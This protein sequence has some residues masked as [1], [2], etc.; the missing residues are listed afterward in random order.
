MLVFGRVLILLVKPSYSG[1]K[2]TDTSRIH[3]QSEH[4]EFHDNQPS[5]WLKSPKG[6]VVGWE[7]GLHPSEPMAGKDLCI[8][9]L[10]SR[11]FYHNIPPKA[12]WQK[13]WIQKCLFG[14]KILLVFWEGQIPAPHWDASGSV[15]RLCSWFLVVS[16]IVFL[17]KQKLQ[18][19]PTFSKSFWWQKNTSRNCDPKMAIT[20]KCPGLIQE[21]IWLVVVVIPL[22]WNE[23]P[24][25]HD[26]SIFWPLTGIQIDEQKWDL[27]PSS[28]RK[29][30]GIWKNVG[31][32]FP[33]SHISFFF[34][35]GVRFLLQKDLERWDVSII[36]LLFQMCPIFPCFRA[37][38]S[39]WVFQ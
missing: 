27:P 13:S 31:P 1:T 12:K 15:D 34:F 35:G 28:N 6:W 11:V 10:P 19:I 26:F 39:S 38:E 7:E 32:F 2:K 16:S 5:E 30:L 9:T 23:S 3:R 37:F 33:A 25:A 24:V 8:F 18:P 17:L 36:L 20:K 14:E 21:K 29:K 4:E 22:M